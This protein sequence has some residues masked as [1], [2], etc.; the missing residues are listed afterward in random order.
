MSTH[1]PSKLGSYILNEDV[2]LISKAHGVGKKTAERI[3]LELRDKIDE[4]DFKYEHEPRDKKGIGSNENEAVEALVALGYN[5]FEAEK[6]VQ[7]I[8]H[9]GL[10]TNQATEDILRNALKF[11]AK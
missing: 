6:A 11:L 5:K 9:R 10:A 8:K 1:T 2:R 3:I 7:T 4:F